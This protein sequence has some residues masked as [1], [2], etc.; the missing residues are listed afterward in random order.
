MLRLALLKLGLGLDLDLADAGASRDTAIAIHLDGSPAAT[1]A[2]RTARCRGGCVH[3]PTVNHKTQ[4][5]SNA[6]KQN[7]R[8]IWKTGKETGK[9]TAKTRASRGIK[10]LGRERNWEKKYDSRERQREKGTPVLCAYMKKF[11]YSTAY[12]CNLILGSFGTAILATGERTLPTSA[13]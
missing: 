3:A 4:L 2:K 6:G 5:R 9:K 10:F 13:V 8:T 11:P 12:L 1:A 7:C